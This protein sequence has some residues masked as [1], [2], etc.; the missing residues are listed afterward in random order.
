MNSEMRA[1]LMNSGYP[2]ELRRLCET[3]RHGMCVALAEADHRP[4]SGHGRTRAYRVGTSS[5]AA[6]SNGACAQLLRR[7]PVRSYFL[8]S[9]EL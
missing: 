1:I 8:I 4:A 9:F 3:R 7:T 2:L 5:R 6:N